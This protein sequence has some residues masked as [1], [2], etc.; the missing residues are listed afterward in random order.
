[1]NSREKKLEQIRRMRSLVLAVRRRVA[2]LRPVWA[3]YLASETLDSLDRLVDE[4]EQDVGSAPAGE[5]DA[6]LSRSAR[7]R[8]E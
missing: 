1:M 2:A 5:E 6:L 7:V 8:R 4:L 3:A